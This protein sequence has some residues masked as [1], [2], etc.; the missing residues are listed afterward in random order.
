MPYLVSFCSAAERQFAKLPH[1]AQ[2]RIYARASAL[3]GEPRPRGSHKL[4][5]ED[6]TF[7]IRVGD[8]RVL[9]EIR[10]SESVIAIVAIGPRE[11][12]YRKR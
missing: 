1:S 10:E 5:G 2:E 7:R 3:A 9:Y 11:H 4:A 12:V 6:N 8:Y